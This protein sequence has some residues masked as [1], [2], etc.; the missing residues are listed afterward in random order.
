MSGRTFTYQGGW[1]NIFNQDMLLAEQADQ[2]NR[3]IE[4]FINRY[5]V[6]ATNDNGDVTFDAAGTYT[7]DGNV[8]INGDLVTASSGDR[9]E[10]LA[11]AANTINLYDAAHTT[12]AKITT[13]DLIPVFLQFRSGAEASHTNESVLTLLP[14]ATAA[15]AAI[16]FA[17]GVIQFN[18]ATFTHNDGAIDTAW[19]DF[20]PTV[21]QGSTRTATTTGCRW[22]RMGEKI[23]VELHIQLTAAGSA[24]TVEIRDL[25]V[26]VSSSTEWTGY[27]K[28]LD[29]GTAHYMAYPTTGTSTTRIQLIQDGATGVYN[30]T[31]AS[32]DRFDGLLTY[33]AA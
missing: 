29:S 12:P 17:T 19:T 32:G 5:T 13:G 26:A 28:I 10:I 6:R 1:R 2:M 24:A 7:F 8:V 21:F 30:T 22:R 23:E 9:I 14:G 11:S 31:L 18:D 27:I 25:P 3:Q 20:T 16:G 4:E 33:K 15:G